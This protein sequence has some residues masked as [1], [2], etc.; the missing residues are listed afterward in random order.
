[1][2][3]TNKVEWAGAWHMKLDRQKRTGGTRLAAA[4]VKRIES[5]SAKELLV[6][7][8]SIPEFA[9]VRSFTE[10]ELVRERLLSLPI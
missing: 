1:M 3:K 10:A 4:Q 5:L 2:I 9:H 8:Q 6:L 7:C